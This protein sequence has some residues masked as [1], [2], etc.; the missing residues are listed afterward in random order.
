MDGHLHGHRHH[1]RRGLGASV[2]SRPVER[3]PSMLERPSVVERS[4]ASDNF[5]SRLFRR[6]DCAD[7]DTSSACEKPMSGS[8]LTLPI[9][10][11]VVIP[12]ILAFFVLIYLHRRTKRLQKQEDTDERYKSMDFGMGAGVPGK[13]KSKLFGGEKE[14]GHAKGMSMDM[15]LSS[16]YL[17]PPA[18]QQSRESFNSLAKTL[19]NSEDP[20]RHVDSFISDGAS[21]RSFPKG[22]DRRASVITAQSGLESPRAQSMRGVPPRQNSL[23]DAHRPRVPAPI[24]ESI[25]PEVHEVETPHHAEEAKAEFRFTEEVTTPP[26]VG[27]EHVDMPAMPL[28][29]EPEER[30]DVTQK[31][32]PESFESVKPVIANRDSE[33]GLGIMAPQSAELVD[34]TPA[35]LRP[36]KPA[37]VVSDVPSEYSDFVIEDHDAED[38]HVKEQEVTAPV[39]AQAQPQSAGLAVPGNKSNRL[40]VGFRPL[41]PSDYLESEDPEFRANRIRSFY[42]EY[43]D[44]GSAPRPPMPQ[45]SAAQY[46]DE[47][48][49][50]GYGDAAYFDPESNAFVMPYAE[51]VT[52]RAM[53]PPPSNRRPMPGPSGR[54][55]PRGPGMGGPGPRPRAGSVMSG[56]HL[57][58]MSPRPGSSAS[59]RMGGRSP[60]GPRKPMPPPAALTTLP[61]PAMLKDESFMIMNPLDFAPPPTYKDQ[62]GGRSQSPMGERRPYHLGVPVSS[63]LVSSFD[64]TPALPSPHA[65]RKS[66]T[67]TA[68]DF[69]PPRRFKDPENM[70]DAGSVRSMG[71]GISARTN[72]ALRQGAGRVSRLPEDE[73]FTQAASGVQLKPKWGMR[74]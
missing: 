40:S 31:A 74:D 32:R 36:G 4:L 16:P 67:F 46:Y 6:A 21:M 13:R 53:T 30:H 11:A 44:D 38:D 1:H 42:K 28:V 56:R 54:G 34:E 55:P 62:A 26:H 68:L 18:M 25:V 51:P 43:F 41:P 64:D 73:I 15:N 5:A 65:M 61:T 9:T 24:K 49:D 33:L 29:H 47:S 23:P 57:P 27:G 50:Q 20:Y 48:H 3:A 66:G 2:A 35:S 8:S 12:L 19:H 14:S 17:L 60:A 69:A 10:L 72:N 71:S 7:G 59:A 39:P 70:S 58:P 37:R 22:G 45:P 52:R 63:P